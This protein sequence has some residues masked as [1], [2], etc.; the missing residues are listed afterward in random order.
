MIRY[1]LD[2]NI[3]SELHRPKPHGAVLAWFQRLTSEQVCLSAVTLG[4]LQ[5]GIE[6]TRRQDPA[7][8]SAIE[9]WVDQLESV[10]LIIPMDGHCFRETARL[11]RGKEDDLYDDAMIAATAR[12]H[13]LK[14]ATRN[15]R[16]FVRLAVEIVNPFKS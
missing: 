9:T 14:V 12:I 15:E 16:D 10:H 1:L 3:I 7:K 4:E 11:M 8:A 13:G 5:E 6:L 2:T